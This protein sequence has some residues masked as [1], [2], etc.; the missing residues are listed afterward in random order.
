ME[1]YFEYYKIIFSSFSQVTRTRITIL[2]ILVVLGMC[3]YFLNYKSMNTQLK[4]LIFILLFCLISWIYSSVKDENQAKSIILNHGLTTGKIDRHIIS[5]S[6]K[7]IQYGI[8]YSYLAEEESIQNRY[9]ENAFVNVPEEKPNLEIEYLVIYEKGN[10]KN[11][12]ILLNYPLRSQ[13]DFEKYE[14]IFA[15]GIPKDV[16]RRD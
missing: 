12:F 2:F 6:G 1:N 14:K 4:F 8:E 7:S 16:F 13:G 11:S 3:Y 5:S 15:E 10:P 9:Y